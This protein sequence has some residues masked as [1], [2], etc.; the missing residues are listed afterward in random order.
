MSLSQSLQCH[1]ETIQVTV[2]K[3]I[4]KPLII[5]TGGIIDCEVSLSRQRPFIMMTMIEI[6][7][8]FN[9]YIF[10]VYTNKQIAD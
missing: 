6:P 1:H 9:I 7:D 10:I 8:P 2:C 4:E 3:E 5:N